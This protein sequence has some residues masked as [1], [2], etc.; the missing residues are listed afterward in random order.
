MIE[1][2]SEVE[3]LTAFGE[4]RRMRAV[5]G[6]VRGHSMPVVHVCK[7]EDWDDVMLLGG[8]PESYAWPAEHVREILPNHPATKER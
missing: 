7:V 3:V 5:T 2:G 6:V 1:P 8:E 4:W